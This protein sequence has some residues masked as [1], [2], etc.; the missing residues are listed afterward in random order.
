MLNVFSL[1]L[2]KECEDVC[3]LSSECLRRTDCSRRSSQILAAAEVV[4]A[5]LDPPDTEERETSPLT[6]GINYPS[7]DQAIN[8]RGRLVDE[9]VEE[10]FN[11]INANG[12]VAS[13]V[14]QP[15]PTEPAKLTSP[16]IV[17]TAMTEEAEEVVDVE[18][19]D[20][21]NGVIATREAL[22]EAA[23]KRNMTSVIDDGQEGFVAIAAD[24]RATYDLDINNTP[25]SETSISDEKSVEATSTCDVVMTSDGTQDIL[26]DHASVAQIME[27][28]GQSELPEPPAFIVEPDPELYI[29]R[30]KDLQLHCEASGSSVIG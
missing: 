23:V 14:P 12:L 16:Q 26:G 22:T 6:D 8:T 3:C 19:E 4:T 9:T 13:A 10:R 17:G 7:E 27:E 28:L 25:T 5:P 24:V 2:E 11:T 30:A 1:F 29:V 15:G 18:G 21:D 20:L